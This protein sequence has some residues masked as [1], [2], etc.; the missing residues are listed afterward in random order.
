[1]ENKNK[2]SIHKI[3]IVV[4]CFGTHSHTKGLVVK[5]MVITFTWTPCHLGPTALENTKRTAISEA[6]ND[7]IIR[8]REC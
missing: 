8:E 2:K 4:G 1:M 5:A 6:Q 7:C 3:T